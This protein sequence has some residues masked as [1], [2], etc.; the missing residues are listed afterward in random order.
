M[1]VRF[2]DYVKN[3]DLEQL[4]EKLGATNPNTLTKTVKHF[5]VKE[6][7]KRDKIVLDYFG[8]DSVKRIVEAITESLQ[9]LSF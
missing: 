4:F 2:E 3:V 6:D 5:T 8:E 9:P 1:V 7:N